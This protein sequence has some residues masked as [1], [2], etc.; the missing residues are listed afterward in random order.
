MK[1]YLD[2]KT[3]ELFAYE[4]DGSQDEFIGESLRLLDDKGLAEVRAAQAAAA[5]PT[6]EQVLA[7]TN[8][9]RDGVLAVATLRIAPLQYAVDLG[10]ATDADKT[11]L[12]LWKQYSIDVNRVTEQ[13]SYPNEITWP[14]PPGE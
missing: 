6:A 3:S 14:T 11:N 9:K 13:T 10:S 1:Y 5:A 4:S 8:S 2:P 7:A 12:Q